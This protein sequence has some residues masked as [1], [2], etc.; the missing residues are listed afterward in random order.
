[1]KQLKYHTIQSLMELKFLSNIPITFYL[2]PYEK[3][4]ANSRIILYGAAEV[5]QSYYNQIQ[6]N[7][8]CTIECWADI[9]FEE[10][11]PLGVAAPDTIPDIQYDYIVIAVLSKNQ[12]ISISE[13]LVEKYNA[14][15][16]HIIIHEPKSFVDF[17]NLEL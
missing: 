14:K 4:P 3:V 12:A 13:H 15:K 11:K 6:I 9:R 7:H 2:F 5:G 17:L 8:Y 16:E 10:L 1:M